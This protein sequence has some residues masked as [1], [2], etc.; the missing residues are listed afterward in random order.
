MTSKS[1]FSESGYWPS[2]EEGEYGAFAIKAKRTAPMPEN[3]GGRI[4]DFIDI[5]KR[6]RN[7]SGDDYYKS[8]TELLGIKSGVE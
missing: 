2:M 8:V 7:D 6:N 5:I 1:R 3:R 4:E